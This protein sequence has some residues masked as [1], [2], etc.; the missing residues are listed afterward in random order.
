MIS[1]D[2]V[3][4]GYGEFD[5]GVP[6]KF[7]IDPHKLFSAAYTAHG[8]RQKG[9]L[10]SPFLY[11]AFSVDFLLQAS[12]GSRS[13]IWSCLFGCMACCLNFKVH[14]CYGFRGTNFYSWVE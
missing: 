8:G 10:T 1:L 3:P 11:W 14:G 2:D 13:I 9:R 7:V 4:C 5:A 12:D 6:K